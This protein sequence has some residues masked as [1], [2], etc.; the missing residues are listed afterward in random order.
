MI[1]FYCLSTKGLAQKKS[2]SVGSAET[3]LFFRP[4]EFLKLI[5]FVCSVLHVH[6]Y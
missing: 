5:I 4:Y 2:G 6:V 3:Q 1:V